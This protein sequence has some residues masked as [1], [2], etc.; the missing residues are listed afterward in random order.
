MSLKSDLVKAVLLLMTHLTM[1]LD[2]W[3][4]V[5]NVD[6]EDEEE[7]VESTN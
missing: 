4:D 3:L 1:D 7:L 5:D 2:E 6:D